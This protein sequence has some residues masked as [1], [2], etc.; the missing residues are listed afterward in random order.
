[1]SS[2]TTAAVPQAPGCGSLVSEEFCAL[3]YASWSVNDRRQTAPPHERSCQNRNSA[4]RRTSRFSRMQAATTADQLRQH[5]MSGSRSSSGTARTAAHG[6]GRAG[7]RLLVDQRLQRQGLLREERLQCLL[8]QQHH[9]QEECGRLVTV[10]FGGCDGKSPNCLPISGLELQGAAVRP[11]PKSWT[12]LE[13]SRKQRFLSSGR[14]RDG[15][16]GGNRVRSA[17]HM[18]TRGGIRFSDDNRGSPG[19]MIVSRRVRPC[20]DDGDSRPGVRRHE[21]QRW[22]GAIRIVG[23]P[24]RSYLRKGLRRHRGRRTDA[25]GPSATICRDGRSSQHAS[26]PGSLA[27]RRL[28]STRRG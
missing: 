10:Q 13:I 5:G 8:G 16:L 9:R 15:K 23:A 17:A 22:S 1:M 3:A 12:A 19:P 28:H 21:S 20:A 11:P 6:Q 2:L 25:V 7:R 14:N 4:R 24:A 27:G 18:A 26:R